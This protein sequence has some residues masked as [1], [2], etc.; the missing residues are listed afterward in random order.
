MAHTEHFGVAAF[1]CNGGPGETTAILADLAIGHHNQ[2]FFRQAFFERRQVALRQETKIHQPRIVLGAAREGQGTIGG[3]LKLCNFI[4]LWPGT[5]CYPLHI[6]YG[7]RWALAGNCRFGSSYGL[8]SNRGFSSLSRH[9]GL[10][11]HRGGRSTRREGQGKDS[12]Q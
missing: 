2:R 12:E 4:L 6:C 1:G 10:S 11:Y 5:R 3:G 9:W 8:S 7:N